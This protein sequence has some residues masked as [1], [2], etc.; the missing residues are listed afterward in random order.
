[1]ASDY[2]P[3][4]QTVERRLGRAAQGRMAQTRG[5]TANVRA[6]RRVRYGV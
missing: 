6:L 4:N 3:S 1:M 2:V 5:A